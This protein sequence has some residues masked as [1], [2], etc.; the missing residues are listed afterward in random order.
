MT[1]VSPLLQLAGLHHAAYRSAKADA[2]QTRTLC[3]C[4]KDHVVAIFQ[5]TAL[6]AVG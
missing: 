2:R 5:V 1:A 4:M 6:F 3:K